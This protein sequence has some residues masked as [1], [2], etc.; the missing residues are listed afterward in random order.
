MYIFS[1]LIEIHVGRKKNTDEASMMWRLDNFVM[2]EEGKEQEV[3]MQKVDNGRKEEKL[4]FLTTPNR[5]T[6]M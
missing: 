4:K 6:K 5:P 2:E 1:V 3:E